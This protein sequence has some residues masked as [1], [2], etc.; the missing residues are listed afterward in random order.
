MEKVEK[1]RSFLEE[2]N[3]YVEIYEDTNLF[4]EVLDSMAL[5]I[6]ITQLEEEYNV[7]IELEKIN[8]ED[9]ST[10]KNIVNL[11]ESIQE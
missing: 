11:V 5:L 9:F 10:I 6:L 7:V 4:E 1:I 3:P 8:L 2:I